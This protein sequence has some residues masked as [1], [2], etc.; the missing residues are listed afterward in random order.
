MVTLLQAFDVSFSSASGDFFSDVGASIE[1]SAAIERAAHDGII[2]G[3]DTERGRPM[4]R[5]MDTMNRA[6]LAKVVTLALQYY[7]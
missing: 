7:K 4:F 5:P 6:E 2:R 3:D 1:F